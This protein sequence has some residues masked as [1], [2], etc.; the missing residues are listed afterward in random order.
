MTASAVL[1][2]LWS[3]VDPI[4]LRVRDLYQDAASV[5]VL[6]VGAADAGGLGSSLRID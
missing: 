1:A 3:V 5:S 2:A 6:D 4:P